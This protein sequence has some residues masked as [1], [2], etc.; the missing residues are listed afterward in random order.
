MLDVAML[1][2]LRVSWAA[3]TVV[4]APGSGFAASVTSAVARGGSAGTG[5]GGVMASS[6]GAGGAAS[7]L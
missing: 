2:A 3:T 4:S 5:A 6:T 1:S 7:A